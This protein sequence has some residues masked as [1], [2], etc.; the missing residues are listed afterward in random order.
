MA[1]QLNENTSFRCYIVILGR[2]NP[3]L[4]YSKEGGGKKRKDGC[5]MK[6]QW[7]I[8]GLGYSAELLYNVVKPAADKFFFF[9][10]VA[11]TGMITWRI[12]HELRW[13]ELLQRVANLLRG[14]M[15]WHCGFYLLPYCNCVVQSDTIAYQWCVKVKG[16]LIA[17]YWWRHLTCVLKPQM[18]LCE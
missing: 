14:T 1:F 15:L 9:S 6:P 2:T 7:L 5:M 16:P 11:M 4:P 13:S 8:N 3:V 12:R 17:S 10:R 18:E